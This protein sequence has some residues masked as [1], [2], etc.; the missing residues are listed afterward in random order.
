[1]RLFIKI[2]DSPVKRKCSDF[3]S[4]RRKNLEIC[5]FIMY[6]RGNYL[7]VRDLK[8]VVDESLGSAGNT[9]NRE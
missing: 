6:I 7:I 5:R 3:A 9:E 2:L 4:Q 8:E 1:M